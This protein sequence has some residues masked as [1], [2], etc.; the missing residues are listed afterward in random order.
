MNGKF[1][2]ADRWS[3]EGLLAHYATREPKPFV[4]IDGWIGGDDVIVTDDDGLGMTF[5]FTTELMNG[6]AVRLLIKPDSDPRKIVG[7]LQRVIEEVEERPE[8]IAASQWL[9]P[10]PYL[11]E[12][13]EDDEIGG[14]YLSKMRAV[15][16][17]YEDLAGTVAGL[18]PDKTLPLA[19]LIAGQIREAI[20]SRDPV[21]MLAAARLAGEAGPA[22]RLDDLD[23]NAEVPF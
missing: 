18:C 23:L 7:L 10:K 16:A 6:S 5:G 21:R 20:D 2:P 14:I 12:P 3:K 4:Q 22:F 8:T 11:V 13:R 15:L 19:K 1:G 17:V 9:D